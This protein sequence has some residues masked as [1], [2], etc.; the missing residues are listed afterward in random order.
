MSPEATFW[1]MCVLG[2]IV[3]A[4]MDWRVRRLEID[5]ERIEATL[6][7]ME[8]ALKFHQRIIGEILDGYIAADEELS[9]NDE[10]SGDSSLDGPCD[11]GRTG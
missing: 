1:V 11:K 10:L 3:Y 9:N 4:C 8:K 7:D 5:K 6:H 2:L